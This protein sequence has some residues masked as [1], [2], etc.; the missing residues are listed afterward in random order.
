MLARWLAVI[1]LTGLA[2]AMTGCAAS[3]PTPRSGE[4][5]NDAALLSGTA[6]FGHQV[7]A[8]EISDADLRALDSAMREFVA[9]AV[10]GAGS[11]DARV[12]RL[13]WE[14]RRRG[15]LSLDYQAT[16][17]TTATETFHARTGNCLAFT[18]LF[19]A[20]AREANLKVSYQLVDIPPVWS[21]DGEALN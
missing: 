18:N 12:Q 16:R 10:Q 20:L 17:T 4:L 19:V 7:S 9:T 11:P 14:M 8:D 21:S 13:F 3:L 15:L 2:L 6:L 5:P 1:Y